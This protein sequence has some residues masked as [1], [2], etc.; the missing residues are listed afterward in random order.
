MKQA[1]LV[2]AFFVFSGYFIIEG[3]NSFKLNSHALQTYYH[4]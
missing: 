2:V 4:Y 3:I 1:I